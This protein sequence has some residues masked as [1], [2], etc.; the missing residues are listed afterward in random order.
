MVPGPAEA[1]R[2]STKGRKVDIFDIFLRSV[3]VKFQSQ[4]DPRPVRA[5]GNY[6]TDSYSLLFK[7]CNSNTVAGSS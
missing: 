7:L 6:S 5:A 4:G 3:R 2:R 1:T